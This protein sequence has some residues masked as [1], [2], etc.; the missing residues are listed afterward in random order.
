[1]K[2]LPEVRVKLGH[3]RRGEQRLPADVVHALQ[4]RDAA[5]LVTLEVVAHRVV[6][7]QQRSGD[8]G[9]APTTAQQEAGSR[10]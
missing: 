8:T 5:L 9:G 4:S 1:M 10:R 6:V 3:L 7:D 2:R